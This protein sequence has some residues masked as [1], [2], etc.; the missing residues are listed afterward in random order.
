MHR[1]QTKIESE[2]KI[3]C[4]KPSHQTKYMKTSV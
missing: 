1:A 3:V 2:V 4:N